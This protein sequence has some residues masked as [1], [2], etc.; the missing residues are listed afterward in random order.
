MSH[1]H[2][3]EQHEHAHEHHDHIPQ[4]KKILAFSFIVI[5]GFM[6]IEFLG[7]YWFNSLALMA[8][9]GHMANDS[10]SLFSAVGTFLIRSKTTLYHHTQ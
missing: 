7:G 3:H 4:N 2:S 6:I 5:T 9:A 8:D 10:L 1:H